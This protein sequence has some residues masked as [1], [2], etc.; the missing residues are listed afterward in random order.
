MFNQQRER[1]VREWHESAMA[2]IR[3]GVPEQEVRRVIKDAAGLEDAKAILSGVA[4]PYRPSP[5]AIQTIATR[6]DGRARVQQMV[7]LFRQAREEQQAKRSQ[8]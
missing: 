8:Q 1:I 2:A 6:P 3:L 7:Q 5:E 4:T